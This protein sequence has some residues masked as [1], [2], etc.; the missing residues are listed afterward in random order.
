M[1]GGVSIILIIFFAPITCRL[2]SVRAVVMEG[3]QIKG[4]Q[5]LLLDV[6]WGCMC[7]RKKKQTHIP[8]MGGL[9]CS[10]APNVLYYKEEGFLFV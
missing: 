5:E 4:C 2:S 10:P 7:F 6:G 1:L 3:E 9:D 8:M